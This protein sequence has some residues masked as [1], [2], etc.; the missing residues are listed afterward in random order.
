MC[1]FDLLPSPTHTQVFE[2]NWSP[3]FQRVYMIPELEKQLGV[4]FPP[5][6]E[7]HSPGRPSPVSTTQ[8]QTYCLSHVSIADIPSLSCLLQRSP[9]S[10]MSSVFSTV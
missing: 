10:S 9:S 5:P 3:P 8:Q 6:S 2:V 7:F 4:K 1:C